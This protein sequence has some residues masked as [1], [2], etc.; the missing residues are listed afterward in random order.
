M[1]SPLRFAAPA[2]ALGAA[3]YS[4]DSGAVVKLPGGNWLAGQLSGE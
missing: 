3:T 2:L 1:A 4:P